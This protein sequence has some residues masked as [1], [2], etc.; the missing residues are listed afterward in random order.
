MKKLW[1]ETGSAIDPQTPSMAIKTMH[2]ETDKNIFQRLR[3]MR[4]FESW[5]INEVCCVGNV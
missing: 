3:L 4:S 5:H 2:F 1:T